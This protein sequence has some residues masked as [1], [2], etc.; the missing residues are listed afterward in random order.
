M[1]FGIGFF[2]GN[3]TDWDRFEALERGEPVGEMAIPD[4]QV[5]S[6]QNALADLAEPLG[7][8]TLWTFEQHAAPYL[9]VPDPHQFLSY[10][11]GRTTRIDVGSMIAVLPWHNPFRLAE[12]VS[13][14]QHHLGPDRRYFMGVGRGLARRN[15]DAMGVDME[16]S[17]ERFNEVLDILQLAFTQEVF[18]YQGQ[19]FRYENASVRPR[20]LDP[21]V[22]LD[23]WGAWTSETSLR[24]M[25][26]RGLH[27]LTT[28]N[29]T[30]EAYLQELEEFVRIREENGHGPG[31]R[32]VLQV[33]LYCCES[34]QEAREGAEHF[35]HEYADSVYR[36]YEIGTDRFANTKGFEEYK[37][38]EY[39]ASASAAFGGGTAEDAVPNLTAKFLK[40]GIWGTPEQCAEKVAAHHKLIDPS[41]LV[42]LAAVGSMTAAQTEKSMRLYVEKVIPRFADVRKKDAV[43]A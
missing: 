7:F 40:D 33:P 39:A 41:E 2:F 19:F 4:G 31:E 21:S 24:T 14:L 32:P 43:P 42:T 13:M 16:T 6:E 23:A 3:Y 35:F 25:A 9:M 10:F 17:R 36:Q 27:P 12:Q 38:K 18:S 5:V 8:D 15:F 30:V 1:R 28:P 34:E 22:V 26:E 29:K 37:T 20:P 11:A